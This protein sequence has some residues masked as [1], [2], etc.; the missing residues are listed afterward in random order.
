[1]AFRNATRFRSKIDAPGNAALDRIHQFNSPLIAIIV[2][3]VETVKVHQADVIILESHQNA[4]RIRNRIVRFLHDHV[5][6]LPH[7][8]AFLRLAGIGTD[9][10]S[11]NYI[12]MEVLRHDIHGEIVVDTT[13]I[14]QYGI[15]FNRLEHGRKTHG[16]PYCI[17][18]ISLV[19][20][21]RTLV[22]Y[23]RSDTAERY[24]KLVEI[25]MTHRRGFRL[26]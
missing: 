16:S 14:H 1:M 13:V 8:V 22:V 26:K 24:K 17:T 10:A 9:H 25:S 7:D 20:D 23:I 19:E 21:Q 5:F 6:Q 3:F 12:R 2:K 11:D 18:Q 4:E 15:Y